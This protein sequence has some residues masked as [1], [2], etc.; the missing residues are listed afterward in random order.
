MSQ[1]RTRTLQFILGALVLDRDT[2][3]VRRNLGESRFRSSRRL[4]LAVIHRK[5][6]QHF[7]LARKDRRRP[8]GAQARQFREFAIVF[9]ER[10]G[11]H[12]RHDDLLAT[13]HRSTA[14]TILWPN[15]SA[16]DSL[17]I[18][19]RQVWRRAVENVLSVLAEL[20]H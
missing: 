4:R 5:R 12:V 17:Y 3:N 11:E 13:I 8:A 19:L 7:S 14:G 2:G 6:P 20:Q 16:V 1:L 18:N 9:P 10:I 15:R